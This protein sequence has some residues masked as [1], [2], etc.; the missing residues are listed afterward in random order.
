MDSVKV[1]SPLT[2]YL[3][4][5]ALM[6]L[7]QRQTRSA[8]EVPASVHRCIIEVKTLLLANARLGATVSGTLAVNHQSLLGHICGT[9]ARQGRAYVQ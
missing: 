3:P 2:V 7:S 5:A 4:Y 8:V 9:C 6:R 1:P